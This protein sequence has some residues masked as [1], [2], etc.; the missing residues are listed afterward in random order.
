ML[1]IAEFFFVRF[2]FWEI[3]NGDLCKATESFEDVISIKNEE[4]EEEDEDEE[5]EEK[6]EE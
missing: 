2:F 4:E 3:Y 1:E 5:E 6:E